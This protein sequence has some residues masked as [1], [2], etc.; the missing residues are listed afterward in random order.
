MI[1]KLHSRCNINCTYCY[2]Y[3]LGDDPS[4]SM[5][6]RFALRHLEPLLAS[7][8]REFEA[9]RL[10][11]ANFSLHG[12]EPL[13]VGK[14]YMRSFLDRAYELADGMPLKL[15]LQ[16]NGLLLDA[17]WC[18]LF[19]EY[20][21]TVGISLDVPDQNGRTQAA[22]FPGPRHLCK[23]RRSHSLDEGATLLRR[24]HHGGVGIR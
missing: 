10:S 20:R 4:A 5:P 17:E 9:K 24:G 1:I 18:D 2:M 11:A 6:K 19:E 13:L 3:N 12:G 7:A 8:R 15:T 22:R 23:G 21:V 16:T 14:A